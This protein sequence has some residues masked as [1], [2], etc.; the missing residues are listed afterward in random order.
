MMTMFRIIVTT[1]PQI[2]VLLLLGGWLDLLWGFNHTD[3]GFS[4]LVFLFLLNP[5]ATLIL[6]IV[7]TTKY[8]ILAKKNQGT[9][10]LRWRRM[11]VALFAEALVTN[12][13]IL[14]Q[15]RM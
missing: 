8:R 10:S 15:L 1:L 2:L 3:A 9:G 11:S 13:F 7:E 6:L 4:V 12:L 5:I 14:S